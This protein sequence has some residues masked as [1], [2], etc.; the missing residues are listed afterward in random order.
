MAGE[1]LFDLARKLLGTHPSIHTHT[2]TILLLLSSEPSSSPPSQRAM[3]H[4]R[5]LLQGPHTQAYTHT[6]TG[7]HYTHICTH[8]HTLHTHY[9]HYTHYTHTHTHLNRDSAPLPMFR[10]VN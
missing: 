5:L 8:I 7:T 10:N 9:T 1:R 3:E 4:S 6:H 2:H